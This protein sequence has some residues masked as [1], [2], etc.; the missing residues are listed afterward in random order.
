MPHPNSPSK[1]NH[2]R[3]MIRP[4]LLHQS[5]EKLTVSKKPQE[6]RSFF[7]PPPPRVANA[8][9]DCQERR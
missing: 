9:T 1:S 8:E 6:C 4:S 5:S 3:H 2:M 7:L